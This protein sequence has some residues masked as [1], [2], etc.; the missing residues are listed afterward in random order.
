MIGKIIKFVG[1]IIIS[2]LI[3]G[4]FTQYGNKTVL[5]NTG[6]EGNYQYIYDE[7]GNELTI[8]EVNEETGTIY[9]H[10][11]H[12]RSGATI[13][14]RTFGYNFTLKDSNENP[15]GLGTG[16]Y[17]YITRS[18]D[19]GGGINPFPPDNNYV[20][21]TYR[22]EGSQVI[23]TMLTLMKNQ[24]NS[25]GSKKYKNVIEINTALAKGVTVYMSNSF[26]VIQRTGGSGS[27]EDGFTE[28]GKL[29]HSYSEIIQ[30][31]RNQFGV[32]WSTATQKVLHYYYD[33]P[34]II[35]LKPFTY[36]VVYIDQEDYENGN[37]GNNSI[38]AIA[39]EGLE[40]HC[41]SESEFEIKDPTNININGSTYEYTGKSYYK[42]DSSN[43]F[44][45]TTSKDGVITA[46]HEYKSDATLYVLVKSKGNI[47]VNVKYVDQDGKVLKSDINGGKLSKGKAYTYNME[48]PFSKG[49]VLYGYT[50]KYSYVFH[51][52]ASDKEKTVNTSGNPPKFT[53]NDIKDNT[54][55]YL[56]LVYEKRDGTP[57][58]TT[59]ISIKFIDP[60]RDG[61]IKADMFN[62]EAFDVEQGIP[63]TETLYG[64][65]HG[66]EYLIE[67]NFKKIEGKY[68]LPV[69]VSK[70]YNLK[71][72]EEVEDTI[73]EEGNIIE[74]DPISRSESVKVE[75]VVYIERDYAYTEISSI[76]YYKIKG[77]TLENYALPGSKL[78]LQPNESVIPT[79]NYKHYA[80]G[81]DI[82]SNEH[83]Q[84]PKQVTSGVTLSSQSV[85][86]G[87]SRPQVPKEN[88]KSMIDSQVDKIKARN[89]FLEFNSKV[90]LESE[91][92]EVKTSDINISAVAEPKLTE[93]SVLYQ[94][95]NVIEGG[96][97]NGSYTSKG[98]I[99]Y[100]RVLDFNSTLNDELTFNI[101]VNKVV[102]HTPTVCDA[103]IETN[104][105]DNQMINP[106]GTMA[107]LVLD[108]P[109]RVTLPTVGTH[110][111]ITGYG[112]RDYGKY[113]STRQVKFP[114][115]VYRGSSNTGV[116]VAKNTWT[117]VAE[118]TQFYLPTWVPEGHYQVQYR[119]IAI[120]A[121][122]NYSS[123]ALANLSLQNYV[124]TDSSNVEVSGRIY[125]LNIYDI[126]DY[127]VWE[128]VF[129]QPNSI[130][131]SGFKYLLGD[132]DQNGDPNGQDLKY[133]I[134]LVNGSHPKYNNIG[135]LKTGYKVRYSLQTVGSMYGENDYIRIKPRFFYVDSK[136]QNRTEVDIYY[137]ETFNG[138]TNELVKMG[139]SLDLENKKSILTGNK[140][141]SIDERALR[142]TA[143]FKGI[144]LLKW[145]AQQRNVYTFTN[146]MIPESLR[147]FVGY[148][149]AVPNGVT[150]QN[151]AQSVQNWYGEYYFP[152]EIHVAE[153]G[154]KVEEYIKENGYINYKENFWLKDGYIIVNFDI[155]TIKN[156]ERHLS[157][158]NQDNAING[159]CNMWKRE[160]YQYEKV[161]YKQN[162]FFFQDGD[163]I[164]YYTNKSANDDYIS[165]GT[166]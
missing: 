153:K 56:T 89:D 3:G 142:Q 145:K 31:V 166:H 57:S 108:R 13:A 154:F 98:Q 141:L 133:T 20:T 148:Q 120:N 162:K 156:G 23:D 44:Y 94:A 135:V 25:D 50:G 21:D 83:L 80:S 5:A 155:E 53:L 147:T 8:L 69:K 24:K 7:E 60:K 160:G 4:L 47:D 43:K 93:D 59:D 92:K 122:G 124:A 139:S 134:A 82:D 81:T 67:A 75:E 137:T 116:F 87:S 61:S 105:K 30:E 91:Y 34:I 129:R 85:N 2:I 49:G 131:L 152:S 74:H 121:G 10:G 159:Y 76:S 158:I 45:D 19:D 22:L 143:Y 119:S 111:S 128:D 39:S 151:I 18:E 113:I 163:F 46:K 16:N 27:E 144:D 73:D 136:G 117:S 138:K 37:V 77:A 15:R 51:S 17:S 104:L 1:V 150:E 146:I 52:K 71:W 107:S 42:Y 64:L 35:K 102:I 115:D 157:Y 41:G 66:S 78:M 110:R 6:S 126:T 90:V 106:N 165:A 62:N 118:D 109:F 12:A 132:K 164:M 84:K 96:K 28:V 14:Y 68:L 26:K 130:K 123:E 11:R 38:L 70:T 40:T 33:N 125:G 32:D 140:F 58:Q 88:F 54:T 72:Y 103:K 36:N 95:N 48:D 127:P 101:D 63:T 112:Y 100:E 9:L 29:C 97:L 55:V 86:G 79:L 161:D 149:S 65:V 114:F 99:V